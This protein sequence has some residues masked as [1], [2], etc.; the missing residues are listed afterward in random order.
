MIARSPEPNMP[1]PSRP[2]FGTSTLS[3]VPMNGNFPVD[4]SMMLRSQRVTSQLFKALTGW[5]PESPSAWEGWPF[6]LTGR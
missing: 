4:L 1:P 5:R 2:R 6:V 3:M